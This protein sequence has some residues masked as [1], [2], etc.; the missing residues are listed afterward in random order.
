MSGAGYVVLTMEYR[1]VADRWTA[2]CRELGTAT[3]GRTLKDAEE[4]INEAVLLHLNTLEDVGER[5][6]FFEEHN[7]RVHRRRPRKAPCVPTDA[8][9]FT[10]TRV[11]RVPDLITA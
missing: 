10:Q 1:K 8:R 11:Q 3:F 4:R 6:R 5:E 9:V 2:R 7:I